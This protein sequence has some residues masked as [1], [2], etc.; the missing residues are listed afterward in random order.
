[1]VVFRYEALAR[2]GAQVTGVIN[3]DTEQD[4]RLRLRARGVY[5]TQLS[6]LG[7]GLRGY[8]F[9]GRL[10]SAVGL[11]HAE[12]VALVTRQLATLTGAGVPLVES[13][14]VVVEQLGTGA[15]GIALREVRQKLTE[16]GRLAD[17][18]AAHPLY[19]DGMYVG[20]VRAGEASGRLPVVFGALAGHMERASALRGRVTAAL[21][22]PATVAVV[23][24]GVIAFFMHYVI[25]RFAGFL[26]RA[27]RALP[28]PTVV[29]MAVS[30]FVEAHLWGIALGLAGLAAGVKV[31]MRWERFCG[32]VDRG[33][34]RLP[35]VGDIVRKQLTYRFAAACGTLLASGIRVREALAIVRGAIRNRVA[36]SAVDRML[37]AV[38]GGRDVAT[39][40]AQVGFFPPM[41]QQMV[42]VGE[43]SGQLREM[44]EMVAAAYDRE[45][46][47]ALRR[48]VALLEP[49]IIVAMAA[50]VGFIVIAVLLP[51]VELSQ[52]TF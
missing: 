6:K 35:V 44:L 24:L 27:D 3:A 34:L 52:I 19:F 20:M 48:L 21:V 12:Q 7:P 51:I 32:W 14:A 38:S 50:V 9:L 28:V 45:V 47:I 42:A 23:G 13:L 18:L 22:Y 10:R 37:E 1:M 30:R 36:A 11:R 40:L 5:I 25:P 33:T 4:A 46:E 39:A 31:L 29:L 49:A 16:G 43:R 2:A 8:R 26:E 15:L 41:V 17:A